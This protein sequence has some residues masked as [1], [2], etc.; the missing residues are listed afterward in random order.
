MKSLLKKTL[1]L[2]CMSLFLSSVF[3][4]DAMQGNSEETKPAAHHS[5]H[6]KKAKK[7]CHCKSKKHGH[8]HHKKAAHKK[9]H[10]ENMQPADHQ[11]NMM[12]QQ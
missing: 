5:K 10:D 11:E 7:D 12:Q 3:A 8:K 1:A 6:H 4:A 2:A 9:A